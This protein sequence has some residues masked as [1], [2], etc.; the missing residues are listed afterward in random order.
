M[1]KKLFFHWELSYRC[2]YETFTLFMVRY[3]TRKQQYTCACH[4][5]TC[6]AIPI[7]CLFL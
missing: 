3:S 6:K 7:K 2:H 4:R 1:N 5:E